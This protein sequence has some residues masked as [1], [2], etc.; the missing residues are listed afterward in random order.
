MTSLGLEDDED[1]M[2]KHLPTPSTTTTEPISV[3]I[4][5]EGIYWMN[6]IKAFFKEGKLPDDRIEARKLKL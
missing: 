3:G 6:P 2:I 4:V 1:V 5:D